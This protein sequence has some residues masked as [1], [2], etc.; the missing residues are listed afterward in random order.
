MKISVCICLKNSSQYVDFLSQKAEEIQ[1]ILKDISFEF[2][3]YENNSIDSTPAKIK[4]FY[5]K[6]NG[7]YISENIKENKTFEFSISE[8]R[9]KYM[10]AIRNRLKNFHGYLDSD[11]TLLLDADVIFSSNT[12][13]QMIKTLNAEGVEMVSTFCID[14]LKYVQ[15]ENIHYYDTLAFIDKNDN[16]SAFHGNTCFYSKCMICKMVR[17]KVKK[18]FDSSQLFGYSGIIPVKSAFGSMSMLKTDVY[19]KMSWEG[20][21]LCEHYAFCKGIREKHGYVVV[22]LNI[23]TLVCSPAMRF[24][25]NMEKILSRLETN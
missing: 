3:M 17:E 14:Y 20:K 9:S 23:K 15:H 18:P 19:N 16:F 1:S 4:E 25:K 5:K 13:E 21:Y 11:Y 2:Y 22:N 7:R 10:A 24:Y 12:I 6:Y 8:D